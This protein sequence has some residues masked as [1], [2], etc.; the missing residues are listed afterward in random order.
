MSRPILPIGLAS[1]RVCLPLGLW[2]A[3]LCVLGLVAPAQ[4]REPG[5]PSPVPPG[6][7][8]G[9]P[10]GSNPPPGV[11]L[12]LRSGY[13]RAKLLD[14]DGKFAGQRNTLSPNALQ[15]MWFSKTK[16]LGAS[17]GA[18]ITIPTLY[19]RQERTDP[20]LEARQ[21]KADEFGMLNL[22]VAPLILSWQLVPGVAVSAG[23]SITMPTGPFSPTAEINTGG[24]MWAFAPNAAFSYLR[25]GWN[26][27][28][29]GNYFIHTR[30]PSS[31]YRSGDETQ[32]IFTA[33]KDLGG[34]VSAGPV[35]YLRQQLTDDDNG[36]TFYAG[37]EAGHA[38]QFGLGL[39]LAKRFGSVSANF[40]ATHDVRI[41][42]SIGGTML[43]LSM[44]FALYRPD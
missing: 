43:W 9:L 20:F 33:M 11:Y 10:L 7:T 29:H 24:D 23:L 42:N 40:S 4:A 15:L 25:A 30:N 27:T 5:V 37:A 22:V 18:L 12:R 44:T 41:R 28:L 14:S 19:N 1:T 3:V 32:L 34:V 38:S 36:G 16:F 13:W 6:Y 26:L 39:G 2:I 21:G 8:M 35:G 17:Y 31:H